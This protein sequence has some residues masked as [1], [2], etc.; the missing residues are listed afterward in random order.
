MI[1]A[2]DV[3]VEPFVSN[4]ASS[5]FS[6]CAE[7]ILDEHPAGFQLREFQGR[8]F[9]S[10]YICLEYE[11]KTEGSSYLYVRHRRPQV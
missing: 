11:A 1:H 3:D 9:G 6:C 8:Q 5:T 2:L 10:L 4:L 7:L